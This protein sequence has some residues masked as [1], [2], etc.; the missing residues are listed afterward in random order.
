[1]NLSK[2]QQTGE[3][4]SRALYFEA[5]RLCKL[6]TGDL[7]AKIEAGMSAK[8]INHQLL[9][10]FL[11]YGFQ[12]FW[13]APK[14]RLGPDTV[15]NFEL[16][17]D[18]TLVCVQG[19]LLS[20]DVGP[21][22]QGHEADYGDTFVVGGTKTNL[23]IDA[24]HAVFKETENHWHA[25]H[26]SGVEL[27]QFAELCA[28]RHGFA[29]NADMS[30]HRLG[31]YPHKLYSQTPLFEFSDLPVQDLWVLEIHLIDSVNSRG[32]FFEDILT[33]TV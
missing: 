6:A 15:K 25:N 13:H 32:A 19:D 8:D 5:R 29:L 31:D 14:V 16:P 11:S 27:F 2:H 1:L 26:V 33:Q 24:C 22:Y 10:I 23:L 18:E 20:L 28:K 12:K 17:N 4:F 9:Q 3:S 30:G 7:V 21:I